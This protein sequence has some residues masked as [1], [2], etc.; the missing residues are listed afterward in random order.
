MVSRL[1]ALALMW[2]LT[3]PAMVSADTGPQAYKGMDP[4]VAA[5][6][7]IG[8]EADHPDTDVDWGEAVGIVEA[9]I[10]Q[11]MAIVSDYAKYE[12]F[13]PHFKKSKVLSQRG[14]KALIYVE[15]KV[16]KG[17]LTVWAQM[18]M[19]PLK[20]GGGRMIVEGRMTKG[21]L[22]RFEARWELTPLSNNRTLVNFKL[23]VDPKVPLPDSLVT[24][25]NVKASRRGIKALRKQLTRHVAIVTD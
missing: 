21:N 14:K 7:I 18:K 24:W 12:Q 25:E 3:T 19:R 13:M 10:G 15:A 5:G 2:A 16:A 1:T 23:L 20:A 17:T 22:S 11:V 8:A 6:E 4:K 9:P